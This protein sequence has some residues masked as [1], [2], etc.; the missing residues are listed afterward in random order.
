MGNYTTNLSLYNTDMNT[1]GN[2]TFDFQR[3]LNDNNDKID[4]FAGKVSIKNYLS[5]DTYQKDDVVMSIIDNK[6]KI[7]KS[8]I[9]NNTGNAL[10]DDTK[11][12]EVELGGTSRDIGEIVVSSIPLIGAGM[13]LCDGSLLQYGIYKE[14]IDYIADLYIANP[15]ANYFTDETTWQNTVTQYGVCGKFVYDSTNK[16]VRLPKITG[17]IEGTTDVSALGNLVQAGLPLSWF[18]HKH[19]RGDMNITGSVIFTETG[20]SDKSTIRSSSGAFTNTGGYG[21]GWGQ[22]QPTD[23][24]WVQRLDF[25][26]SRNW[27]GSTSTPN[28]TTSNHDASTVQPQ[29]IKCFIYIV[30]ATSTKTDI[31]VDIDE[32]ATDLNGKADTDLTN[33]TDTAKILMG[34]MAMPSNRYIDLTL[35][36]SGTQY[37]APADGYVLCTKWTTGGNY[38][39]LTLGL[40]STVLSTNIGSSLTVL[41][42]CWLPVAKGSTFYVNYTGS[43]STPFFRFIYAQGSESEAN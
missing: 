19:T 14:F 40:D 41:L 34:G 32:I 17:I 43:G 29:T 2:D 26:A 9:A 15:T 35:G 11:W 25:D 18:E 13:H 22:I 39:E 42:R 37:T 5:N 31:Q 21:G 16:T 24:N 30:I 28:Y 33:A 4:A 6:V 27:T 7:Y 10:T 12:E 36:A 8:L 23:Q 20:D 1:D 3:D 38:Q